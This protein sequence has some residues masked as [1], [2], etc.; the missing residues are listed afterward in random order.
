M[1]LKYTSSQFIRTIDLE[2]L[3]LLFRRRDSPSVAL[4]ITAAFIP[5]APLDSSSRRSRQL[6]SLPESGRLVGSPL[7]VS[8]H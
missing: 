2:T 7:S 4:R 6:G 5:M 1:V 8:P 3:L